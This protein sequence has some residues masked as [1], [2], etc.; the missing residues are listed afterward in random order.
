MSLTQPSATFVASRSDRS[1]LLWLLRGEWLACAALVAW[2]QLV[3]VVTHSVVHHL[4]HAAPVLLLLFLPGSASRYFTA[5][6]AGFAWVFMLAVVT[7]MLHHAIILGY[8]FTQPE[9]AYTWLAPVAAL[10]AVAWAACG[11]ALLAGRSRL[12][13]PTALSGI[14]AMVLLAWVQPFISIA[15]EVP[16][17]GTLAGRYVWAP[18]LLLEAAVVLVLPAW[19]IFRLNPAL[20]LSAPFVAAQTAYWI[21]FVAAMV[22][23]LMPIFNR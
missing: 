8:A 10:I 2:L 4:L 6:L 1:A 18:L 11:L 9:R 13:L 15:F 21:F 16:L 19:S 23:G 3:G 5:V 7:P 12:L 20:K 22:A 17:E 14:G